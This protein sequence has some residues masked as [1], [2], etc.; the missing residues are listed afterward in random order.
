MRRLVVAAAA[1]L[2][3][4]GC[5]ESK[6][7]A[8][9][10]GTIA[11]ASA[12][13]CGDP[14][15]QKVPLDI[16]LMNGDGS[17]RRRLTHHPSSEND[18]SWSPN[19]RLLVLRSEDAVYVVDA[20]GTG[21]RKL[22]PSGI[23]PIWSPSGD[24][25]A[26]SRDVNG[27]VVNTDGTGVRRV[28]VD[29]FP[30]DWSPD[31]TKIAVT[32]SVSD[33]YL[34]GADGKGSRRVS[35]AG[36]HDYDPDWSPDGKRIAYGGV[37]GE[38]VTTVNVYVID[39]DGTGERRL[40]NFQQGEGECFYS[41]V[42]GIDWS[43]DGKWIAFAMAYVGCKKLGDIYLVRPDGSDLTRLTKSGFSVDPA[44]RPA[45]GAS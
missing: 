33:I 25:I 6:P 22:V 9:V 13:C 32:R 40:T 42:R 43:P 38:A 41:A 18:P 10:A 31:G 21:R 24:V 28:F 45:G 11:F 8:D 34:I 39:A 16:W 44:W 23:H 30:A 15:P 2:A 35:R 20:D 17:D 29:G 1:V 4:A 27:Y 19:G 3:A 37:R 12:E 36:S 5:G 14:D 7:S 26:F